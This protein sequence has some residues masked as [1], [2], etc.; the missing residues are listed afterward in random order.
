MCD[1]GDSVSLMPLSLRERL[2]IG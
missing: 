1:L 2:G